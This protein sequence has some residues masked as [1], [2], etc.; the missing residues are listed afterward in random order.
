MGVED[1]FDLLGV[2]RAV[3]GFHT[4]RLAAAEPQAA[5][6]VEPADIAHAVH[7]ALAAIGQRLADLGQAGGGIAAEVGVGGGGTGDGD[8]ADLA[9]LQ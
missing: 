2:E 4:L 8:F 3:G 5:V 9:I 1:G 7:G 6:A